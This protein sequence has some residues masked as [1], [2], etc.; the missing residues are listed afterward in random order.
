MKLPSLFNVIVFLL[1][2]LVAGPSFMSISLLVLELLQFL[3][4]RVWPEIRKLEIPPSKFCPIFRNWTK[5]GIPSLARMSLTKLYSM[6]QNSKFTASTLSE[7][8]RE[9]Q[10]GVE[11]KIAPNDLGWKHRGQKK[12]YTVCVL[13]YF[14]IT[15]LS[16]S[17]TSTPYYFCNLRVSLR[18]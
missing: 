5:L 6:L 18:V 12:I 17:Q 7:L 9:N 10:Q 11:V 16:L 3:F 4:L 2:I 13:K 15:C 8:L 1:S 14:F